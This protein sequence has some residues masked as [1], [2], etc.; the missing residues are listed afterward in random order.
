[1]KTTYPVQAYPRLY[2]SNGSDYTLQALMAVVKPLWR[3]VTGRLGATGEPYAW[4][5]SDAMGHTLWHAIDPVTGRTVRGVS[6]QA[7]RTWL[8]HLYSQR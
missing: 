8:D 7:L 3:T 6:D 4:S 1:M 2:V 5:T